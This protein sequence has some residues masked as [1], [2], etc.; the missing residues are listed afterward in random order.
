MVM[1]MEIEKKE[2]TP[3]EIRHKRRIRN[4]IIAYISVALVF[5]LILT[6]CVFAVRTVIGVIQENNRMKEMAEQLE[7]M[8]VVE[9]NEEM[10]IEE[11]AEPAPPEEYT[12]KDLLEE[13]VDS[14]IA[15]MPLEDKVAG[16]FLITP[17][18]LTGANT[19]TA[20]GSKTEEALEKY[21]VGGLIYFKQ[22][23][24]SEA[25]LKEMISSTASKSKYPLFFAV[26]EE[27]GSVTRLAAAGLNVPKVEPMAEIGASGDAEAA[28]TAGNTIGSY[29]GEYGV[30]L[31]FAPVADVAEAG[32]PALGN[33]SFGPDAAQDAQMVK[34]AVTG[35]QDA[36]ISACIKHF[37]GLGSAAEDTHEMAAVSNRTL[38]ELRAQDLLPFQAG[39]DA[40]VDMVMVGHISLPAV[41]GDET[42]ASLSGVVIHDIL[43]Q[44]LSYNGVVITD[45]LRMKAVSEQYTSAEAA[46]MTLQA[47]ADMILMPENFQEAY[48]GVLAAVGDGTLT[49]ERITESLERIYRVK[50]RGVL[51]E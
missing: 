7:A 8:S 40:G 33:R 27:G 39:I 46:V 28:Y 29:L 11:E 10:P 32:H 51:G 12:E 48:E 42:P 1:N 22:N 2:L 9:A 4:Q 44:E 36:G 18:A 23:I 13:V 45:A 26:D 47:G 3:R 49:E 16:L 19:V 34:A 20:A 14:C 50:Y 37:P 6:G 15:Q 17:E 43:R 24:Q 38:E 5:C 35:M 21:P 25:Q 30:N 41:I 31:N